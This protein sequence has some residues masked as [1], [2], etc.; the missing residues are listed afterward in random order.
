MKKSVLNHKWILIVDN[1]QG[2]LTALEEE[3]RGVAPNCHVDK[4]TGYKN[5]VERMASFTYD[6]VILDS[7]SFRSSDLL[8]RA[9]N[10]FPPPPVVL[11]T[12]PWLDSEVPK[13]F[14]KVGARIYPP[15]E[16]SGE[17]ISFL[18]DVIRKEDSPGWK[19]LLED[20]TRFFREKIKTGWQER[21]RFEMKSVGGAESVS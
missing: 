14:V 13:D 5:A 1:Q 20:F 12:S 10:R 19:R 2:V 11:M 7:L 8:Y 6:L 9:V 4:A 3:L 21:G 16:N 17:M 18:E 15:K